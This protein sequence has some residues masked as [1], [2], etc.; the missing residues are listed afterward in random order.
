MGYM[1]EAA[2]A[3]TSLSLCNNDNIAFTFYLGILETSLTYYMCQVYCGIAFRIW[4]NF[5]V[6]AV[7]KM[8]GSCIMQSIP[9]ELD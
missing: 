3:Y 5:E 1:S 7:K 2:N 6:V 4:L 8:N 9:R